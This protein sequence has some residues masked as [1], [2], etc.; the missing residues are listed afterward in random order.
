[1]DSPVLKPSLIRI[2]PAR[3]IEAAAPSE[4]TTEEDCAAPLL[5][6]ETPPN[7]HGD[8]ALGGHTPSNEGTSLSVDATNKGLRRRLAEGS[9]ARIAEA[10]AQLAD[11][12]A[13][14]AETQALLE[15]LEQEANAAC[16]MAE[17][18]RERAE[19]IR[20]QARQEGYSAGVEQAE[21][22]MAERLAAVAALAEGAVRARA[23][24]L[25]QCEPEI[26][27]L[28][29]EI[30]RTV[31]GQHLSLH[32]EAIAEVARRALSIAGQADLYYLHLHPD[33]AETVERYLQRDALGIAIQVVPDDR[34]SPG[35]CL[36]RTAYGRVNA[37]ID[38]QLREIREQLTGVV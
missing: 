38:S 36:I 33:A 18:A 27:E 20:E 6:E 11:A 32:P 34:L 3:R 13:R 28:A 37:S 17:E 15:R 35:D 22:D 29:F 8:H 12:E 4:P 23:E 24:F 2:A 1:M 21:R 19:S 14:L 25:Q 30:A 16:A 7:D 5:I 26:V 10:Q 31:L 9:D